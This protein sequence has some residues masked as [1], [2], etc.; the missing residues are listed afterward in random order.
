MTPAAADE[1]SGP[2]V[3]YP[4]VFRE[5]LYADLDRARS[6]FAQRLGG[7]PEHSRVTDSAFKHFSLGVARYLGA[8]TENKVESHEER[9]LL[10]ALFPALEALLETEQWLT[11]ISDIIAS[12]TG[13][14]NDLTRLVQPGSIVR[15]T[16]TGQLFDPQYIAQVLGGTS[17]AVR[18]LH[19]LEASTGGSTPA[20]R[21]KG[22]PPKPADHGGRPPA[23][24]PSDP[25]QLEDLI[26]SFSPDALGGVGPD[27]FR[28]VIRIARGMF[29]PGLHMQMS[30]SGRVGWT[31]IARL[32]RG[33]RYLD[34]EPEVLF[35][36]YGI[37]PQEW[38]VVGTIG[39]FAARPQ[40][41]ASP[42]F[43]DFTTD[44]RISRAKF[45]EGLNTFLAMIAT[46]GLSDAPAYPGFSI[47]PLA[48]YR[49]IPPAVTA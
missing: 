48:V 5:F 31:A 35:S 14:V 32:E 49:L 21:A 39:H 18:G 42:D 30:S 17:A 20:S 6:L 27:M 12:A 11:D 43:P 41:G 38:T 9:S 45:V 13:D 23:S 29:S 28:A 40:P 22:K 4:T 34:A 15:M 36:R 2:N 47:I 1:D 25:A 3:S 26:E 46:Q 24:R 10:D 19:G 37:T 44:G 7:V 33:R 8:G 16:C